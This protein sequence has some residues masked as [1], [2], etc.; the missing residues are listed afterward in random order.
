MKR[1]SIRIENILVVV[2]S[3]VVVLSSACFCYY[4]MASA[5]F[6]SHGPKFETF[7]QEFLDAASASRL[8]VFGSSSFSIISAFCINPI[9]QIPLFPSLTSPFNQRTPILLC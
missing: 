7:D 8:K 2:I 5:D 1:N 6:I 4:S 9:K 3:F